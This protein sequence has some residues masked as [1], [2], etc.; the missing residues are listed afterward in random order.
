[1]VSLPT[2]IGPRIFFRFHFMNRQ[3]GPG[4]SPAWTSIVSGPTWSPNGRPKHLRHAP[5]V[6]PKTERY[7]KIR[8]KVP[9]IICSFF[10]GPSSSV[11]QSPISMARTSETPPRRPECH[12]MKMWLGERMLRLS[13]GSFLPT[14]YLMA[15]DTRPSGTIA[16]KRPTMQQPHMSS[17]NSAPR[18][19]LCSPACTMKTLAMPQKRKIIVSHSEDICF[20][21]KDARDVPS[22]PRWQGAYSLKT[23]ALKRTVM[24]PENSITSAS[25]Y[26]KM[27]ETARNRMPFDAECAI[28]ENRMTRR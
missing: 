7:I 10:P 1:M 22:V 17:P 13:A 27:Q 3:N 8:T 23:M 18:D 28:R 4:V 11:T 20:S 25:S 15:F 14:W 5:V 9:L 12:I 24:I 2:R 21:K 6:L 16:K 26:V 19:P